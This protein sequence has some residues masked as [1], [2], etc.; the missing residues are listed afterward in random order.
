MIIHSLLC[1][2]RGQNVAPTTFVVAGEAKIF[3]YFFLYLYINLDNL[4]SDN[5]I[6]FKKLSVHRSTSLSNRLQKNKTKQTPSGNTGAVA[7]IQFQSWDWL[8]IKWIVCSHLKLHVCNWFC[9]PPPR[10]A[11]PL[12]LS[13]SVGFLF[14]WEQVRGGEAQPQGQA[15][16]I[17]D[18]MARQST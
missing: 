7:L 10:L 3:I 2:R 4:R 12:V 1:W 11:A 13:E 8:K 18:E 6:W 9:S 5:L 16:L 14:S 17:H 15:H